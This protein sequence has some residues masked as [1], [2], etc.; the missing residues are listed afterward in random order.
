MFLDKGVREGVLSGEGCESG[1]LLD[2]GDM[3]PYR[4]LC[5]SDNY[6]KKKESFILC[7]K[8]YSFPCK[9]Q[10]SRTRST[11]LD[12]TLSENS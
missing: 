12:L 4:L 5:K 2:C 9:L 7:C 11:M 10:H 8:M 1:I 3:A 6:L